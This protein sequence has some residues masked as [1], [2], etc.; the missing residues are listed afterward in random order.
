MPKA[1]TMLA[2]GLTALVVLAGFAFI[3]NL[4][5]FPVYYA[6]GQSLGGGRVDL[7]AA[8]FALGR[9]MDYR[10]PPFFLLLFWPL[11]VLPYKVAAY[12]WYLFGVAEIAG[13][14]FFIRRAVAAPDN[15]KRLW[16]VVFFAV[17][18]YFITILHYG[19]AHLLAIFLLFAACYFAFA[20][21]P[22]F[23]GLAMASAIAIKL[24]PALLLPYFALKKQWQML[25]SVAVFLV[26]I[27]LAPATYFGFEKNNE[28]LK[29][30][31][32]HV[33]VSQEFHEANGPIN[34]SLKGQL[35]RTLS[36]VD[37]SQR[38]DGDVQYPAVN[39]ASL[40]PSQ[41]DLAWIGISAVACL[42]V[43]G[44]I[45]T[46]GRDVFGEAF[47]LEIGLLI[48]LMLFVGPLT[49]KIYFIALIWPVTALA[50]FAFNHATRQAKRVRGLLIFVAAVN[51]VLPLLPGRSLQ[52]WLL[53]LGVDFYLNL[54]LLLALVYV[55]LARRRSVLPRSAAPQSSPPSAARTS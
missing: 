16:L 35:R 47:A 30:W 31:F 2:L 41:I 17:A 36:T 32:N 4:I 12:V 18:A 53:V 23:A 55:L 1:R 15:Q 8:D 49:S 20:R 10:Y 22:V 6:A 26:A 19:N 45:W 39:L 50:A 40:P 5:D 52:R 33:V 54:L 46:A 9:V 27:N 13:S 24:T 48:C 42:A 44:F 34:L 37:Y 25:A 28:L 3:R 21:K 14:V 29:T 7:Y 38:V 43:F 51:S 11:W